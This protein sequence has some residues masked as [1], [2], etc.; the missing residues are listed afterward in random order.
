MWNEQEQKQQLGTPVIVQ[1]TIVPNNAPVQTAYGH[2]EPNQYNPMEMEAGKNDYSK[3][4]VQPKSFQDVGFA[5]F[6]IIH[7]IAVVGFMIIVPFLTNEE[8]EYN[9]MDTT[10]IIFLSGISAVFSAV[11]STFMLSFMMKFAKQ[12]VK[13]ALVFS[14]ITS[15]VAAVIGLLTGQAMVLLFGLLSV[16]IGICYAYAV[17]PRIPFAAANLNTSLTAVKANLGLTLVAYFETF[18]AVIW[19]IRWMVS[20]NV[21]MAYFGEAS[22]FFLFLS[23]FWTHQVLQVCMYVVLF[24]YLFVFIKQQ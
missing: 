24:Q 13:I 2:V 10:G 1:G 3:G 15:G 16:A 4:E 20:S 6:F 18:L 8:A 7:L 17:W 19:T 9:D 12:L 14:I 11:L 21:A 22:M 5:I 23:F